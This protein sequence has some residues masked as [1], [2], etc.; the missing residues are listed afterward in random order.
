M[1]V[2]YQ[3]DQCHQLVEGVWEEVSGWE[4]PASW[5]Q[6]S[7][8]RDEREPQHFCSLGCLRGSVT[9]ALLVGE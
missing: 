5:Y 9:E 1:A 3:C 2:W 8:E 4:L 6:L 7:T